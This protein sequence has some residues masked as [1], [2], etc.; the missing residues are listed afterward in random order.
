MLSYK[1]L[2]NISK[3]MKTIVLKFGGASIFDMASLLKIFNIIIE[4]KKTYDKVIVIFSAPKGQTRELGSIYN[5]HHSNRQKLADE[6]LRYLFIYWLN[7]GYINPEHLNALTKD[8]RKDIS[9]IK[10]EMLKAYVLHLGE[11][12]T[13]N[14]I[15]A[16]F[17]NQDKGTVINIDPKEF[18]FTKGTNPNDQE[19]DLMNSKRLFQNLPQVSNCII[20][21]GGFFGFNDNGITLLGFDGSDYSATAVSQI[22]GLDKVYLFKNLG[23]S[24]EFN[25]ELS[26]ELDKEHGAKTVPLKAWKLANLWN[27]E[28]MIVNINNV[29]QYFKYS[30]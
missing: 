30:E 1:R 16:I 12:I 9:K 3:K 17:A 22:L 20:T 19:I 4:F 5:E 24:L 14:I 6:V 10:P 27:I 15:T 7:F 25:L 13:V 26:K 23:D 18:L 11:H 8:I 2:K 29:K 21:V 28:I